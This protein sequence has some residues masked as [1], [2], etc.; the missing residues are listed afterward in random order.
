MWVYTGNYGCLSDIWD[1]LSQ[2]KCLAAYFKYKRV[3]HGKDA[4]V[5]LLLVSLRLLYSFCVMNIAAQ[6]P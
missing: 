6:A 3:Y 5:E 4:F 2:H 1:I